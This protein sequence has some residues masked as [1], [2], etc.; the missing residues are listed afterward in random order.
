MSKHNILVRNSLV[1]GCLTIIDKRLGIWKLL[2]KH[3]GAL[4]NWGMLRSGA[5]AGYFGN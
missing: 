5:W 1:R 4:V 3:T 2:D